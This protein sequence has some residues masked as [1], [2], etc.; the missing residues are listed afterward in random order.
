MESE[1][2]DAQSKLIYSQHGRDILLG[3]NAELPPH[4]GLP[5]RLT[6]GS[7]PLVHRVES[8]VSGVAYWLA[9]LLP[10]AYIPP[11]C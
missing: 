4:E 5:N 1:M 3:V 10:V 9:V 6:R 7:A 8:L 11:F 2:V